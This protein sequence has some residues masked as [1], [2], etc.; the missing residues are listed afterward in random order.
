MSDLQAHLTVNEIYGI[1]FQGEV[2]IGL[3]IIVLR[4]A[5]CN[6]KCVWCDSRYAW[7][8]ATFDRAAESKS[9][10]VKQVAAQ[11]KSLGGGVVKRLMVT[12]GE[13]LLQHAA[14]L[15]LVQQLV[16]WSVYIETAGTLPPLP[17]AGDAAQLV[18][19]NVSPKLAHSG[20]Q[21]KARIV[22][23]A[24]EALR[25]TGRTSW[26]FVISNVD[27]LREVD[28]LVRAFKLDPVWL[29]PEGIDRATIL[30]RSAAV[31]EAA[32]IRGYGFT[33]RLHILVYG[34]ERGR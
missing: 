29:M 33:T 32:I 17:I 15:E 9:M 10:P 7:D 34:N 28:D 25:A 2:Q 26:K 30:E 24:I 8:W 4:L 5:N 31:A 11:I 14:L 27:D 6:L 20:N 3:P 18:W 16:G 19:Y 12:G 22:P 23:T 1:T 21:Q 13:P